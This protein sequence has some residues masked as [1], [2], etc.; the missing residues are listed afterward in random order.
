ML[1]VFPIIGIGIGIFFFQFGYFYYDGWKNLQNM[2]LFKGY[3][4]NISIKGSKNFVQDYKE[5]SNKCLICLNSFD[6]NDK[7][8]ILKCKG[9]HIYH[10]KCI[11]EW[12]YTKTNQFESVYCPSCNEVLYDIKK[13]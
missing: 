3:Y 4:Q 2:F 8:C 6:I 11:Y 9:K 12:Y 5:R 13:I 1:L 10:K 7:V